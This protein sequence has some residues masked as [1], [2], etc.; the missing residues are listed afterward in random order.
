MA[1]FR[2][3]PLQI[4]YHAPC[5]RGWSF[6]VDRL[7]G[8]AITAIRTS[9]FRWQPSGH[10]LPSVPVFDKLA[11]FQTKDVDAGEAAASRSRSDPVVGHHRGGRQ[12]RIGNTELQM[13]YVHDP[14][15][16]PAMTVAE[17][18]VA[19]RIAE[20]LKGGTF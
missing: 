15:P 8:A 7:V 18:Q 5:R 9:C 3:R 14:N 4:R 1:E 19:H 6:R 20:L 10:G 11:L 16:F 13:R 12:R 17:G 2:R